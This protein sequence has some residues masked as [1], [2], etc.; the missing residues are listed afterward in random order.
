MDSS[1]ITTFIGQDSHNSVVVE[2]GV[3]ERDLE[4]LLDQL[5][6]ECQEGDH[7]ALCRKRD[8]ERMRTRAHPCRPSLTAVP[9]LVLPLKRWKKANS[10]LVLE[11]YV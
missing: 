7:I 2:F 6:R 9:F 4:A 5:V 3:D 10:L 8:D 1:G 11:G